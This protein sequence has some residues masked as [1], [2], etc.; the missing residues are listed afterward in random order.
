MM[1]PLEEDYGGECFSAP[2][3]SLGPWRFQ[4]TSV[5]RTKRKYQSQVLLFFPPAGFT[6]RVRLGVIDVRRREEFTAAWADGRLLSVPRHYEPHFD[7]LFGNRWPSP[8]AA[9]VPADPSDRTVR[10]DLLIE[11]NPGRVR[12]DKSPSSLSGQITF[13]RATE[14]ATI[15]LAP[16][17]PI[18]QRANALDLLA[19][20]LGAAGRDPNLRLALP[21]DW[22]ATLLDQAAADR[23][24]DLAR[25]GRL[26]LLRTGQRTPASASLPNL[27]YPTRVGVFERTAFAPAAHADLRALLLLPSADDSETNRP[28]TGNEP[29]RDMLAG[30]L[31]V[32]TPG[33]YVTEEHNL[34]LYPMRPLPPINPL[35]K[36]VGSYAAHLFNR[37]CADAAARAIRARSAEPAGAEQRKRHQAAIIG[38]LPVF[39]SRR[40][41]WKGLGKALRR[42]NREHLSP[43]ILAATPSDYFS[44]L[45]ELSLEGQVHLPRI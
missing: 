11:V 4:P 12:R 10:A 28:P 18:P 37:I 43:Q 6:G 38:F 36:G 34:L 1:S 8:I 29:L 30:A 9:A 5:L 26:E 19:Q 7:A 41:E 22:A 21:E 13:R 27:P 15:Y 2:D 35:E 17:L 25:S 14:A 42:W 31:T 45:E 20:A 40:D 16:I 33:R 32:G 23:A 44:A 3:C 24:H 39:M